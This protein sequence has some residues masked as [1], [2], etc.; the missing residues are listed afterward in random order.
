MI[1]D[2]RRLLE[3][4]RPGMRPTPWWASS[5]RRHYGGSGDVQ[6]G[7]GNPVLYAGYG[8]PALFVPSYT[9]ER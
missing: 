6:A 4:Q 2:T 5:E 9:A 1:E 7:D 8:N 3:P